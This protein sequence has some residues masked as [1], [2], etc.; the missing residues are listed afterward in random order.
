MNCREF[1][2]SRHRRRRKPCP[3]PWSS[4]WPKMKGNG[5]A[6]DVELPARSLDWLRASD[7]H[8]MYCL[9]FLIYLYRFQSKVTTRLTRSGQRAGKRCS[10]RLSISPFPKPMHRADRLR[11]LILGRYPDAI[12]PEPSRYE[13][14]RFKH[15]CLRTQKRDESLSVR[16]LWYTRLQA[17]FLHHM[18]VVDWQGNA[19]QR[20]SRV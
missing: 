15:S 17:R 20:R 9:L 7:S 1:G 18:Q 13:K 16:T 10:N 6:S 12:T 14:T 8:F 3:R 2:I 4:R 11:G 19:V 5:A